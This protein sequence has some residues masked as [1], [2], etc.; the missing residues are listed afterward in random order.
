MNVQAGEGNRMG[1]EVVFFVIHRT[2]HITLFD[3]KK[4]VSLISATRG[5]SEWKG[6]KPR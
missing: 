5:E 4:L 2:A 3:Q 1:N 6:E